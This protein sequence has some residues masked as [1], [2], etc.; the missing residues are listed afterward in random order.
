MVQI[1]QSLIT[2]GKEF[3]K[4]C[5]IGG[6]S[7]SLDFVLFIILF[8]SLGLHY[9]VA[10]AVSVCAGITNSFFCNAFFNFK[11]TDRLLQRYTSFFAIGMIGL[12]I[13][14]LLLFL[15]VEGFGLAMVPSKAVSIVIVAI[16]Q[17]LLNS[18]I[19]FKRS[20]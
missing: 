7:A 12:L 16:T 4:Y 14:A 2:R 10:N 8:K 18:A 13:S 15:F 11:V 9:Q 19:S 6:I 1:P 20:A 5:F 17:Y 3:I